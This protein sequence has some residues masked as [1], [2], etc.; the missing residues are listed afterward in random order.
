MNIANIHAMRES[1]QAIKNLASYAASDLDFQWLSKVEETKWLLH[2][3]RVMS[4]AIRV[5]SAIN[6]QAQTVIV[7]CSDGWDRTGQLCALAQLMLD[8]HYRTLS[9]FMQLIEKEWILVGHKFN[10]RIRPGAEEGM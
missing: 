9:G 4:A 10:D 6:N 2:L 7:H 3:R 8:P 5:A 1:Y